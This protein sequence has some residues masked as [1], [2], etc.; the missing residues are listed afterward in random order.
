MSIHKTLL[1]AALC[2]IAALSLAACTDSEDRIGGSSASGSVTASPSLGQF[3]NTTV[4]FFAANGNT[5][6]GSAE[7]ASDGLAQ[8][9]TGSYAGPVVIEVRGDDDAE[10]FDEAT[11]MYESFPTG[12]SIFAIAPS[13]GGTLAVTPLTDL[14]YRAAQR[15]GLLPLAAQQVNSLNQLVADALAGGIDILTPPAMLNATMS[16]DLAA[17]DAG[18]Y[19]LVLAALAYLGND[20][21]NDLASTPPALAVLQSLIDDLADGTIDNLNAGSA[22]AAAYSNFASEFAA[23]IVSA[24]SAYGG[25]DLVNEVSNGV[26]S[27]LNPAVDLTA[28][29]DIG[30][31]GDNGGNNGGNPGGTPLGNNSGVTGAVD[32]TAQTF[33]NGVIANGGPGNNVVLRASGDLPFR[34]W[35]ITLPPQSGT[36]QCSGAE[37]AFIN[38]GNGDPLGGVN[39]FSYNSAGAGSCSITAVRNNNVLTG[40]FTAT[41]V[42]GGGGTHS[43]SSGAFRAPVPADNSGGDNGDGDMGGG[44]GG[45]SDGGASGMIDGVNEVLTE[46]VLVQEASGLIG[47][48]ASQADPQRNWGLRFP[49]SVGSHPCG[50]TPSTF[51]QFGKNVLQMGSLSAQALGSGS[52]SCTIVVTNL[53]A[54][55]VEGTFSGI[56]LD[57][58]GTEF[59]VTNG[60]FR[61]DRL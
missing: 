61:A 59:P 31:G 32:G 52:G 56:L 28:L 57:N 26:R 24:A 18:R 33:T 3:R 19:A 38:Y 15:N 40:S 34:F 54:D 29:N 5:L 35:E 58:Q 30:S 46:Q 22:I 51:I 17:N 9:D 23:A 2:G 14:A 44:S 36:Y 39:I 27:Y 41:L 47:I 42:D 55:I 16:M 49:A 21:S 25:S 7:V 53:T 10:Y 43:V 50:S 20:G 37:G 45:I 60:A 48:T 6:I 1:G 12:S 8:L 11:G 13:A 4:F